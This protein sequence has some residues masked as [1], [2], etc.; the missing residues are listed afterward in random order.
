MFSNTNSSSLRS[1]LPGAASTADLVTFDKPPSVLLSQPAYRNRPWTA[2]EEFA[3]A[4]P[5]PGA[6]RRKRAILA[7]VALTAT[8][9]TGT[10]PLAAAAATA[11]RP[12]LLAD[13]AT[14]FKL[15]VSAM[16]L[17]T[18]RKSTRLNSS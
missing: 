14:L 13:Y 11:A 5:T 3:S 6:A 17:I 15:R 10:E 7:F 18:D 1:L 2:A 4:P 8:S 12:S 9:Q 16:V